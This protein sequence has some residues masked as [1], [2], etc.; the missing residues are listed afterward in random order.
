MFIIKFLIDQPFALVYVYDVLPTIL[1][2]EIR[3]NPE[4]L[5]A[6]LPKDME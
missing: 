2:E 6:K 5:R 4:A 1:M 3:P